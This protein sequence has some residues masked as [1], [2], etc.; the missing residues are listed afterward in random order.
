MV[1]MKPSAMQYGTALHCRHDLS[2]HTHA[3][4]ACS[5]CKCCH[6]GQRWTP[7]SFI[8]IQPCMQAQVQQL[9]V[10]GDKLANKQRHLAASVCRL[11]A[12]VEKHQLVSEARTKQEAAHTAT[13][14]QLQVPEAFSMYSTQA[15]CLLIDL[16][17]TNVVYRH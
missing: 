9:T 4:R 1:L 2:C 11:E 5:C 15:N 3:C 7:D 16:Q 17:C 12:Q 14:Q 6:A 10:E 13:M 8:V